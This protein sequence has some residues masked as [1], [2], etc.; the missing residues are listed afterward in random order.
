MRVPNAPRRGPGVFVD[1]DHYAYDEW[2]VKRGPRAD[3]IVELTVEYQV[4]D[5]VDLTERV[6]RGA[7]GGCD[8]V[9]YTAKPGPQVAT[10]S[11]RTD[12]ARRE[13]RSS[14]TC[15]QSPNLLA[16]DSPRSLG[17]GVA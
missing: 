7:G 9:L 5:I 11:N 2:R 1:V 8:E 14:G 15:A 13:V 16:T 12:A 10:F 6:E 3:A 4:E 17:I